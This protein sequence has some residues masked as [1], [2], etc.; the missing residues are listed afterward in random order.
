MIGYV[1][2]TIDTLKWYVYVGQHQSETYDNTYFGSGTIIKN[3]IKKRKDALRNYVLEWCDTKDE[4]DFAEQKWIELFREECENKCINIADGGQGGILG[5]FHREA[6]IN[7]NKT[8]EIT[9]EQLEKT[10]QTLLEKYGVENA[11]QIPEAKIKNIQFHKGRKA[12]K[13]TKEMMSKTRKGKKW[14]KPMSENGRRNIS[15]S[16]KEY[17][18]THELHL[19]IKYK[20]Q[21]PEGE[22]R[23]MCTGN[24][25]RW[26]PDW[27]LIGPAE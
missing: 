11:G 23:I 3:I 27:V 18:S 14:D 5:D 22:I 13:E 10:K 21:T 2:L 7:S 8:R 4:L 20:W 19:N 25:K 26:H 16:K 12:S 15:A 17:Y 24:V 6:I 9:K 1:Y